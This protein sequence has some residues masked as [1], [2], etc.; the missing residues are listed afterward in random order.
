MRILNGKAALR[1][2]LFLFLLNEGVL[3]HPR[4]S[5]L[6]NAHGDAEIGAI[7]HGYD[8]SFRE[9]QAPA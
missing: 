6:S 9:I 4:H 1:R 8:R 3:T 7:V 2:A 5:F